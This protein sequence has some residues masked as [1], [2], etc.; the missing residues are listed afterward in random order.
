MASLESLPADQRAV[1]QL[2]L[3]RGRTYDDIASLLS[4][5]RAAV[6]QRALSALDALGPQTGV[7]AQRRALITDYLLGQLPPRVAESV[8]DRLGEVPNER[9]WARVIASELTPIASSALPEIP[10]EPV[11]REP[12]PEPPT[13]RELRRREPEPEPGSDATTL[14]AAAAA[15]A[16][17]RESAPETEEQEPGSV[18]R[19]VL[20]SSRGR[21]EPAEDEAE[22]AGGGRR[23]GRRAPREPKEPEEAT[24]ARAEREPRAPKEP[25][26]G[27]EQR[28]ISRLGGGILIA[29]GV[30]LVIL[31]IVLV[32]GGGGKK[33]TSSSTTAK[34]PTTTSGAS[35]TPSTSTT[36]STTTPQVVRQ[37]NLTSPT[38]PK[39]KTTGLADVLKEGSSDGIAII[40]QNVTP[41]T[42]HD[43]YA[44]WLYNSPSDSHI[45]GFV[46]PGVGSN[47][48]LSTAG[49]LPTNASHYKQLIVTLETQANP[50]VPGKIILQGTLTLT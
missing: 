17:A 27:G 20:R 46:N 26:G 40:A 28:R 15:A 31:V 36:G 16:A 18:A 4:I 37:I 11:R 10:V 2:V 41:N 49:P 33:N 42:K 8:R 35:T 12:E 39:S 47:H 30:I 13:P 38:A 34:A 6:R 9:A 21:T 32:S 3:Q 23:F 19:R 29:L 5:D 22:P 44:V 7:E 43:A 25:R 45:L 24:P 14:A 1:L 50:K 48:R